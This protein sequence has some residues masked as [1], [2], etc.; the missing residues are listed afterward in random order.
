MSLRFLNS[1]TLK[2]AAWIVCLLGSLGLASDCI[3]YDQRETLAGWKLVWQDEFNENYINP[4]VWSPTERRTSDWNNT[5]TTD[6]KVFGIGDGSLHLKGFVNDDQ[7]TDPVP[8]LTGGVTSR[9][10]YSFQYGKVVIRAKFDSARGAWPAL[11]MLGDK[12]GWPANGEIDLMEH[13]NFDD[14]VYQTVH[15]SYTLDGGN[16][17][18]KSTQP[19]IKRDAFNTYGAEWD[20]DKIVFTVNGK[21]THT[22]PRAPEKGDAQWPF[23]QPFYFVLSMQIGGG[24]VGQGDPKDYPA[25]MEIDWVRVYE[26]R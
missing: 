16:T 24:W 1:P 19:K 7:A 26:R 2:T 17:P 9:G 8:F 6:P 23:K 21:H 11:W 20:A 4:E 22:Y 3:A 5:M 13:L 14:F 10:K 18:Q 15:S 12:G 25:E